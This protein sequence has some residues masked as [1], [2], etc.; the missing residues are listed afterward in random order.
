[1]PSAQPTWLESVGADIR[2]DGGA[3]RFIVATQPL[4]INITQTHACNKEVFVES[5]QIST[6][7]TIV[8]GESIAIR[9]WS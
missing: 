8:L 1:M 5:V 2:G 6:P 3:Q 4:A 9:F 7:P